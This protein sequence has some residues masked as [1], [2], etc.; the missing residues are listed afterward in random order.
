[1]GGVI[2]NLSTDPGIG[3]KNATG[4]TVWLGRD[5]S[6]AGIARPVAEAVSLHQK[7]LS[8]QR[9]LPKVNGRCFMEHMQVYRGHKQKGDQNDLLAL[10]YL[11]GVIAAHYDDVT[12]FKPQEWKGQLPEKQLVLRIRKTLSEEEVARL[13]HYLE[14]VPPGLRH[15]TYDSVGIGLVGLGRM[16]QR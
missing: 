10:A 5:F 14:V 9:Q 7:A 4:W 12:L 15:N 6:S 16:H 1:M 11:E 2:S 3:V 8:I 13:D